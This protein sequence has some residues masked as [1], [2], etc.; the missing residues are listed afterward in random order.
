MSS[1]PRP[2][3]GLMSTSTRLSGL[4]EPP[5]SRARSRTSAQRRASRLNGARSRGP[6]T[7]EGRDRSR[8]NSLKHGLLARVVCPPGDVRD[9]DRLFQAI[10]T[11]LTEEFQPRTF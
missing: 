10:R 11:E 4:I 3:G 9:H 7:V 1:A 5:P 6:V 2:H 8:L